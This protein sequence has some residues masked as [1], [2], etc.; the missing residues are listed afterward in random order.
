MMQQTSYV[1][2]G[3]KNWI[4]INHEPRGTY[5]AGNE[6]KFKTSMI[7]SNYLVIVMPI[8]MLK[9]LQ[10]SQTHQRKERPLMIEIE[11]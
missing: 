5:N 10:Q 2:L 4:Q 7:R 11:K 9:D 8:Y 3:E 1:S 6:I